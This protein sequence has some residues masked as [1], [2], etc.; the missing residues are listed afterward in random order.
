MPE[1]PRLLTTESSVRYLLGEGPKPPALAGGSKADWE[2]WRRQF[3]E[4]LR[5]RLGQAAAKAIRER[6]TWNHNAGC[7]T[8]LARM[9][10]ASRGVEK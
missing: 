10:I 6:Y 4:A 8:E 7:L 3:G 1:R 2:R 9:L 5:R